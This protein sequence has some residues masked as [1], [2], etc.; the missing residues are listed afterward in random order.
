MKTTTYTLND[1]AKRHKLDLADLDDEQ[2]TNLAERIVE[3]G[4]DA[5]LHWKLAQFIEDE[6]GG[7][8]YCKFCDER[9]AAVSAHLH[10][11]NWV[12]ACCWDERLRGTE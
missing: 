8:V 10:R 12:G 5:D 11:T 9:A 7:F 3:A 4:A 6:L 2:K 1:A